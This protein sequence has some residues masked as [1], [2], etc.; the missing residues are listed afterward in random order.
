MPK[1]P[2]ERPD[3]Q[4]T[5]APALEKRN[6]RQFKPEYKLRMIAE[7]DACQHGELGALLRREKLYASQLSDWRRAFAANGVAGL[8]K[9]APGPVPSKTPEQRRIEQLEKENSRLSRKLEIVNDCLD[10]QKKSLVDTRS[11][12]Q[13]ERCMNSVVF[14]RP[15]KL[16]LTRACQVLG[17]NR[18][19]VYAHQKRAANDEPPQRSRQQSVQPRALSAEER[20]TVT[21]TLHSAPYCDQPPTEV[22]Q[23]LLMQDQY[24]CSVST[25]VPN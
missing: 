3:T 10:L 21:L 15:D 23:R 17:L 12:T 9:S 18:S 19:T 13:W 8:T 2:L 7:A 16:P 24:L 20:A 11:F 4:V 1:S 6:R 5:P 22:Y 14:H 25:L